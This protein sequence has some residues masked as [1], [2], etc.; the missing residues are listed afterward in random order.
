MRIH[1]FNGKL[2]DLRGELLVVTCFED[3]RPLRGFAG[4]IDWYYGGI[5]SRVLMN[6]TGAGKFG[7]AILISTP[8]RIQVPKVI[9]AG[10]G[11][12]DSYDY[13][14]LSAFAKRV[15]QLMKD[16]RVRACAIELFI[17]K[18]NQTSLILLIV[19]FLKGIEGMGYEERPLDFT[20]I[21]RKIPTAG[22]LRREGVN[23]ECRW[24]PIR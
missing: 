18:K 16:L 19:S 17:P 20:L 11:P 6:Q 8:G 23:G 14:L 9:L 4:E 22:L 5:F 7:E 15:V 12:W 2:T 3:L 13:P 1:L 24:R 10:V 21:V